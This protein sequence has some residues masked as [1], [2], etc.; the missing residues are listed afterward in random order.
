MIAAQVQAAGNRRE[1][2]LKSIERS[3]AAPAVSQQ[4]KAYAFEIAAVYALLGEVD[5]TLEWLEKSR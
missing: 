4:P 5:K 1:E 2:A 3:I